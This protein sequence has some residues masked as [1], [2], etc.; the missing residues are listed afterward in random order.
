MDGEGRLA[1]IDFGLCAEVDQMDSAAMTRA[2]V[3]LMRGD[4]EGLIEDAVAL[5]FLPPTVDRAALLPALRRI[6]AKGALAAEALAR[7]EA[8]LGTK[9]VRRKRRAQFVEVSNDLN[10]IF[11]E[12]PFAVPDY[13]ALITRAL[14]VLEGIAISGDKDFD[15]FQAA[16]P[17]AA[18]HAARLFGTSQIASMLG[19]ARAAHAAVVAD[20]KALDGARA[21]AAVAVA[22]DATSTAAPVEFARLV[23]RIS[24]DV[25]AS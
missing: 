17:Y 11:Y 13:F 7:E 15:L 19:E 10:R 1:L 16:Y 5:R 18:R 25:R 9:S 21:R 22:R 8:K 6:F 23:R 20:S 14:I 12:F 3:D 24:T 4:V 2:I